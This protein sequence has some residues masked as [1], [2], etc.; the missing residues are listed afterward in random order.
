MAD[1]FQAF[2]TTCAAGVTANNPTVALNVGAGRWQVV[3]VSIVIPSGHA[4]LTGLQLWY[5][6]GAAIPYN[7]GWYSGDGDV[8]H[9]ELG[10]DFPPGV[11]WSVAMMNADYISHSWQTRWEMNYVPDSS[12]QP[13][14]QPIAVSD[15]Y[16][17]AGT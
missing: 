10:N 6:G 11:P 4:G 12:A 2:N 7:S 3:K 16:A 8:I 13:S 15:I 1:V 17:A 9:L 14:S 5:G